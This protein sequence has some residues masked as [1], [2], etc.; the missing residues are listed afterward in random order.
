MEYNS[1]PRVNIPLTLLV[2]AGMIGGFYLFLM[3]LFTPPARMWPLLACVV[4]A[5]AVLLALAARK[6]KERW[7]RPFCIVCLIV[8]LTG[9]VL[10]GVDAWRQSIPTV[11][12]RGLMLGKWEPFRENTAAVVLEEDPTLQLTF[13]EA[14]AL[15]IDGATALWPVYASFAANV[16][17][18]STE[19]ANRGED[20]TITLD[21]SGTTGAYRLLINGKRDVVFC[22]A[23]SEKQ[24]QAAAD[25]G[26]ALHMTPIG[27]EAFVFFVNSRN[28]VTDVTV[29]DIQ[30]V[31]TGDVTNWRDLGGKNQRI[32]AFQRDEGS[33]SQSALQQLMAG[34]PLMTPPKE[35]VVGDMGGIISR[36]AAYRN[37][38]GAI[39]Y[40]FRFYANEMVGSDQIRLLAL[41]GVAPSKETIRDGSYPISSF[42]YAVT[43]APIGQP[44]REDTD[45]V[46]RAFLNW[47]TGEQGQQVVEDVGYVRAE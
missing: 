47:C 4:P 36:T 42:F 33:G 40:T 34:L 7:F 15:R 38:D 20:D 6:R 16:F 29:R 46:L 19:Y 10:L 31:Y 5:Y 28:P 35:D 27:R 39:G 24:R 43:A 25:A 14:S 37:Y 12:E 11:S 23:P 3:L 9:G 22:A 32:R 2:F 45:P 30:G 8:C 13:D 1:R 21:C 18:P 44:A 17:E 41:N 26:M